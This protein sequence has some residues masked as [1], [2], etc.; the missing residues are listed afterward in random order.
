[1]L[2]VEEREP[3]Q[4]ALPVAALK[5]QLRLGSGF[6]PVEDATEDAALAGFLRAAIATVEARTGKVLLACSGLTMVSVRGLPCT[7]MIFCEIC[8][9]G[10]SAP[11]CAP[12]NTAR[13]SLTESCS[14]GL[15]LPLLSAF[16]KAATP[17]VGCGLFSVGAANAVLIW[18]ANNNALAISFIFITGFQLTC[19]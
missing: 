13:A 17:A 2:L 16:R 3:D 15:P 10:S 1:M 6:D 14:I 18:L 4:G 5:S 8:A 12:V 9:G 7:V 19:Y 11:F